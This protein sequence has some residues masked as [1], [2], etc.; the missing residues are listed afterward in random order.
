MI[1]IEEGG[2]RG[3]RREEEEEGEEENKGE[4]GGGGE[5]GGK[6][7]RRRRNGSASLTKSQGL[8]F[9]VVNDAIRHW[10]LS[11]SQLCSPLSRVKM[12]FCSSGF[13]AFWFNDSS[14]K[15]NFLSE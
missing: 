15:G 3:G 4:G 6:S 10:L 13:T 9:Q 12:V 14:L 1:E 5:G 7:R 11:I 2:G 8:F